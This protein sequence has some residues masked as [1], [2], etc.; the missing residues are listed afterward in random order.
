MSEYLTP[1]VYVE[2][3]ASGSQPISAVSSSIGGFIGITMRG[4]LNV[5]TLV[6]SWTDFLNKYAQGLDSPFMAN[7]DLAYAVYGF[8]QNGGTKCYI[9]R[10][11]SSTAAKAKYDGTTIVIEA[12]DEGKWGNNLDVVITANADAATKFDVKVKLNGS[13]VETYSALTNATEGGATDDDYWI[14]YI[15]VNSKYI[16]AVS[17]ALA[18]KASAEFTG[19][20]DGI[21]DIADTDYTA[22][23]SHFDKVDDC[24]LIAIPGQT[25]ATVLA[26]I[27]SYV[28]N[29]GD[30]FAILDAPKA[31]TVETVKTLRKTLSC[32]NAALYFPWIKVSDPLSKVGKLRDCP[33]CGHLMGVYART[34]NDRGCWKAPA[35]V[36]CVVRGAV[37]VCVTLSKGDTD[38]LNPLCVNAIIAKPNYGIVVWGARTLNPD[39]TMRYVSDVILDIVV[40]KSIDQGTQSFV[41]EPHDSQ[42]WTRVTATVEAFLDTMWRDGA[43]KG[44]SAAEAYFVKCD[45]ELNTEDVQKQGKLICEV[46]YAQKKPAE[47]VIFRVAHEV[48]G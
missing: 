33:T 13:V 19:G 21:S 35:G 5:P 2:S 43:F 29:R 36:D 12:A 3:K 34:I 15:N 32:K 42:L 17:G 31:S 25:S 47:F 27:N 37:D 23:L 6:T 8:F 11:A 9:D 10:V 24:T 44:D 16:H 40:R 39:S 46:G 20:A 41:F 28:E 30:M 14:D 1:G 48:N 18:A 7:S 4:V 38:V 45:G 26:A 22:A